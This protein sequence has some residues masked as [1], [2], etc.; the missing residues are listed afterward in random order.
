MN[1]RITNPVTHKFVVSKCLLDSGADR[2]LF[3]AGFANMTGHDLKN[4]GC[5]V[6]G[7]SGINGN[8]ISSWLHCFKV[9]LLS[10]D[11]KQVIWRSKE[12]DIGCLD[13]D[14][15]PPLF[16]YSGFLEFMNI[17][18]NYPTKKIVIEI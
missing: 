10:E 12:I 8:E 13:H 4:H 18:F 1:A 14:N 3:P 2:C 7:S 16:G 9:E 11:Y 17:R 15:T 6:I 5:S